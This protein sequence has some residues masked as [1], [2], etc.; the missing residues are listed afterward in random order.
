MAGYFNFKA[1]HQN[2][3]LII[4]D[5]FLRKLFP[6]VTLAFDDGNTIEAHK[7]ILSNYSDLFRGR[8]EKDVSARLV[9]KQNIKFKNIKLLIDYIY[10]GEVSVEMKNLNDFMSTAQRL[11]IK[12]IRKGFDSSAVN[13]SIF[14]EA[15]ASD[16]EYQDN[17]IENAKSESEIATDDIGGCLL[18]KDDKE[19][20]DQVEEKI[21]SDENLINQIGEGNKEFVKSLQKRNFC[22]VPVSQSKFQ[23]SESSEES[24]I[25]ISP[26]INSTVEMESRDKNEE[27]DKPDENQIY[28]W[29]KKQ[30]QLLLQ[31][32]YIMQ[33]VDDEIVIVDKDEYNHKVAASIKKD[34]ARSYSCILCDYES[35]RAINITEHVEQH[36]KN[37]GFSFVC[38]FCKHTKYR[39]YEIKKHLKKCEEVPKELRIDNIVDKQDQMQ[40]KDKK[41]ILPPNFP[42]PN[43]KDYAVILKE[44]E[45]LKQISM[46][47]YLANL[48]KFIHYHFGDKRCSFCGFASDRI[49]V[50][51]E[52]LE[53]KHNTNV[54]IVCKFCHQKIGK[55]R[56]KSHFQKFSKIFCH[57]KYDNLNDEQRT[58][59]NYK[60]IKENLD[61]LNKPKSFIQDQLYIITQHVNGNQVKIDK[62]VYRS[63]IETNIKWSMV[64]GQWISQCTLCPYEANTWD[65]LSSHVE[66]AHFKDHGYTFECKLCQNRQNNTTGIKRHLKKCEKELSQKISQ[67][68]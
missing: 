58:I 19:T 32:Y 10:S 51:R 28:Y 13:Q 48:D 34:H 12:G 11:G 54:A 44:N 57:M 62:N 21:S 46:K 36:F 47:D 39:R 4:N 26:A 41:V 2:K 7:I 49:D 18:E 6:D 35:Y 15:V 61:W 37:D 38:K 50:L 33:K 24:S 63:R 43:L 66:G 23:N 29:H 8:F 17:I 59:E 30:K 40:T 64:S 67:P 14:E 1:D 45:E 65:Q 60:K 56:I 53:K 20:D 16:T 31:S 68:I 5:L 52:H 22:V 55:Y 3:N 42:F 27:Y 9:L 25:P